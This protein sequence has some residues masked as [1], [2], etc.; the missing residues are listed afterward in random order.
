M[1][2]SLRL[3]YT[4][5]S[6]D[7]LLYQRAYPT[8]L[9]S[10][11]SIKTANF[12]RSLGVKVTDTSEVKLKAWTEVH[13][14]YQ[15]YIECL[16]LS[17]ADVLNATDQLRL[18][19]AVLKAKGLEAGMLADNPLLS[20][21]QNEVVN[22][23]AFDR[24][25]ES[26]VLDP[27]HDR[28][29]PE[30][31]R[32]GQPLSFEESIAEAAWKLLLEPPTSGLTS[33]T[34]IS[35]CWDLYAKHKGT[36]IT[37]TS[38]KRVHARWLGFLAIAGDTILTQETVHKALDAYIEAKEGAGKT[39]SSTARE[40]AD[41]LAIL[42]HCIRSKR[43][44]IVISK[45]VLKKGKTIPRK[46]FTLDEHKALYALL[47][48]LEPWKEVALLLMLQTGCISSELQRLRSES[49]RLDDEIPHIR[50][51][52][53]VKTTSRQR[54]VPLVLGIPSLRELV[55]VLDDGSG[56]ALGKHFHNLSDSNLS[57]RLL[58]VIHKVAP[59]AVVYSLRHT[60]M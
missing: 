51:E 12:V 8:R 38:G 41:V 44:P 21:L 31:P 57:H 27:V 34:V 52:G 59:G 15:S 30:H 2:P 45:P 7:N 25:L 43:L 10:H 18:A 14:A 19:M 48:T 17:N 9:R 56:W 39:S 16:S 60:V 32:Y 11:P 4:V 29:N 22:N 26:G 6:R 40:L 37:T 55:S 28:E 33:A 36:D 20:T 54:Y 53:K 49:L 23:E 46:V 5:T 50:I 47:P 13:Q 24:V 1:A 42:R 58:H 3:K 35:E